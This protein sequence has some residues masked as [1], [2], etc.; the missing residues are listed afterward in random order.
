[1]VFTWARGGY[2]G[3]GVRVELDA[4]EA[5]FCEVYL[6]RGNLVEAVQEAFPSFRDKQPK[7]CLIKGKSVLR[8]YSV[9][10]KLNEAFEESFLTPRMVLRVLYEELC[11]PS[12]KHPRIA[13]A[14]LAGEYLGMKIE[15]IDVNLQ[16]KSDDDL[17]ALIAANLKKKEVDGEPE[18]G[19]PEPGA[20]S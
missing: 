12:E 16:G 10:K 8:R 20:A 17:R 14:K 18:S 9:A 13:A 11:D 7:D 1:M 5:K 15:K 6:T 19:I 4:Q 2:Y 3:L